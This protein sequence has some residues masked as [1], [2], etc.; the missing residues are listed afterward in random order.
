MDGAF[1]SILKLFK[2]SVLFQWKQLQVQFLKIF[3]CVAQKVIE[4]WNSMRVSKWWQYI[5]FCTIYSFNASF[6][7]PLCGLLV[8]LL[9]PLKNNNH[10]ASCQ[11]CSLV[12]LWSWRGRSSSIW[13]LSQTLWSLLWGWHVPIVFPVTSHTYTHTNQNVTQ[14]ATSSTHTLS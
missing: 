10:K 2:P 8:F 7:P 13:K 3:V 6:I 5:H 14:S 11:S 9:T 1:V 4:V 12:A